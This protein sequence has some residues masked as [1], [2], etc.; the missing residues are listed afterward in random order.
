MLA[1][2]ALHLLCQLK[3]RG[4]DYVQKCTNQLPYKMGRVEETKVL[5]VNRSRCQRKQAV[6]IEDRIC[7]HLWDGLCCESLGEV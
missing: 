2:V 4:K 6:R 3:G 1:C 5:G 7:P